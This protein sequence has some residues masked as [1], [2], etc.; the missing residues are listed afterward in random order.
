MSARQPT[1]DELY[2]AFV[3]TRVSRSRIASMSL[4]SATRMVEYR[5]KKKVSPEM[6]NL[7]I[8][9]REIAQAVL[10]YACAVQPKAMVETMTEQQLLCAIL[11]WQSRL[12]SE[13]ERQ[14]QLL[15]GINTVVQIWGV[16]LILSIIAGCVLMLL[17]SASLGSLFP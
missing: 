7:P 16:L 4:D 14:T 5:R 12:L 11:D 8:S 9:D 1:D 3:D 6:R 2:R 17:G 10:D 13:Q 15:R